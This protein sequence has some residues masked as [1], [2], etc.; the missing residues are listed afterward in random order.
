MQPGCCVTL[1]ISLL[2]A[3]WPYVCAITALTPELR[4]Q[5][6][7]AATYKPF[8]DLLRCCLPERDRLLQVFSE[9]AKIGPAYPTE[10]DSSATHRFPFRTFDT[11]VEPHPGL[12][13]YPFLSQVSHRSSDLRNRMLRHCARPEQT[14]YLRNGNKISELSSEP[15]FRVCWRAQSACCCML[16]Q[17]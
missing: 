12:R 15:Q 9:L 8:P 5:L 17:Q 13:S 7:C 14:T 3:E 11:C 16:H 6:A 4:S 1:D 10:Q 2:Q